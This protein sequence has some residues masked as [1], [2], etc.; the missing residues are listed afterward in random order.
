MEYLTALRAGTQLQEYQIRDVLGQGGFGITYLA[1]DTNLGKRVALKEYLPRDFAT[2]TT[3]STVVPNS[4]AD[5]ADYRW[6]LE[7]FV[8]EARTLARFDHPHLNKVHRF[9]EAHGTAYLVLE[10]IEGE[11][12]SAVLQRHG[13]LSQSQIERL[14]REVLSGLEEVHEAGYIHRDLKPS[15]LMLRGDGSAVVLDFGAARQAVSQRSKRMTSMGTPGYQPIEQYDSQAERV[16]PWSDLYA[17]GMVAYRCVSG[18]GDRELPYAV[19]RSRAV[20]KGSGELEPAASIGRGQYDAR[21]LRAIDWAI[22]VEEEDRPQSIGEWQQA[23]PPL[24]SEKQSVPVRSMQSSVPAPERSIADAERS[25][26][27]LPRRMTVVGTVAL[28][29]VLVGGAYW[30]GQQRVPAVPVQRQADSPAPGESIP[31]APQEYPFTIVT[32][33]AEARVRILNISERYAAGM[34]LSAGEYRVEV[35]AEGYKTVTEAVVH[36]AVPTE[37]RIVLARAGRQPGE[38]FQDCATCPELVVV[39]AGSYLMGSPSHEE[40]RNANEGPVHRVTI[41][42]PFAVG[43]YEVTFAEWDACVAAGGCN[44]YRP[45]DGG[46]GRGR[47]PVINVS[48][49]DARGY[50]R[51][52]S[53]QT[54]QEYRLLS[55]AE[56][57]YVARVGTT[58][59]YHWGDT[60]GRNRANCDGCGSQWDDEKTAPVGSFRSNGFGLYDVHGNVWEWVQDCWGKNYTG[61]PTN[62]KAWETGECRR[63]VLRGGSWYHYPSSLRSA[64]RIR[65]TS[66]YRNN[67]D[68]FRIARS[69]P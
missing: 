21:L 56:W 38:V 51:W 32:E 30:L 37:R 7:R 46:W 2:R 44:G 4:S 59:K 47:R 50:V 33:P 57:E 17:L 6:G 26:S 8:D 48:W 49:E 9:F 35:S 41:T 66:G 39:P 52:L 28:V 5:A 67:Y 22:E 34:V 20:R 53:E 1:T 45:D 58:T 42:E 68:G 36:G 69:L 65:F 16:G 64:S 43:V 15:N 27:S 25:A 23:L 55:E 31:V 12:L 24:D 18:L 29:M 63:R 3:G 13:T 60:I 11:P 61:A 40:D 10:Y 14:L 62:G 19:T 54:G